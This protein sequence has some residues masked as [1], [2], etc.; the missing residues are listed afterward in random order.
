MDT[1]GRNLRRSLGNTDNN[2]V[3]LRFVIYVFPPSNRGTKFILKVL[4]GLYLGT[5]A[6]TFEEGPLETAQFCW[7]L[8]CNRRTQPVSVKYR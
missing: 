5:I 1:L 8:L 3:F 7:A 2:L 6:D 4:F